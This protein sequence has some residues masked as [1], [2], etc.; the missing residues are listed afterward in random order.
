MLRYYFHFLSAG[1]V[2]D[3]KTGEYFSSVEDAI[4]HAHVIAAELVADGTH[5]HDQFVFVTDVIGNEIARVAIGKLSP[6]DP[7]GPND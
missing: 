5:G 1:I 7:I 3:D 2:Y 4:A 6:T